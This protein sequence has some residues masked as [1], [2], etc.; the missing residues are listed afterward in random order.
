LEEERKKLLLAE[1]MDKVNDR[2][3]DFSVT[4]GSLLHEE[5]KGSHVISPAWRPDGIRCVEVR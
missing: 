5:N 4:F 3:G 2:Y 1:A